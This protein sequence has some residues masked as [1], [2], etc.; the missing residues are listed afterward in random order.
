MT[1]FDDLSAVMKEASALPGEEALCEQIAAVFEAAAKD[2]ALKTALVDSFVA[3][4]DLTPVLRR[5][6]EPAP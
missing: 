1:Y 5:P 3:Q 4:R 2:P 6:V